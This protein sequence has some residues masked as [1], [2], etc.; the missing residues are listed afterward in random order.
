MPV[1]GKH[2]KIVRLIQAAGQPLERA[3]NKI[4]SAKFKHPAARWGPQNIGQRGT[5]QAADRFGPREN[6]DLL[7]HTELFGLEDC[8]ATPLEKRITSS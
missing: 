5:V 2:Q 1:S 7:F 8:P 4:I 3:E 6:P